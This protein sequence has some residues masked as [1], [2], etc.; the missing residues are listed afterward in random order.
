LRIADGCD[1]EAGCRLRNRREPMT[2][3][4]TVAPSTTVAPD[5][6]VAAA[7]IVEP[8]GDKRPKA[9]TGRNDCAACCRR[10]LRPAADV[11]LL[12]RKSA[13]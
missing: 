7:R 1:G 11:A 13:P 8:A 4:Q 2:P 12:V 6:A 5:S 10:Q 3:G 9:A